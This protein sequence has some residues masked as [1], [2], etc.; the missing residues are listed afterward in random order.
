MV[1]QFFDLVQYRRLQCTTCAVVY[2]FPEGWCEKSREEGRSWKCPNGHGQWYGES[3]TDKIR[4][5]RDLLKQRIAQRDD[6]I[7]ENNKRIAEGERKLSATK[8]VVTRIKN[9]VGR[10]VCPCCNRTFEN[11]H[12][13]M[14]GQHPT[15]VSEAA[16]MSHL[17]AHRFAVQAVLNAAKSA[18]ATR[19]A[20]DTQASPQ[21][22][23]A[24][25]ATDRG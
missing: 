19:A 11:L 9:R 20:D 2:F 12:R 17:T 13:H 5:E 10:G 14:S 23:S 6:L 8:G 21:R 15:Y 22:P 24:A 16:E 3:E 7:A 18:S 25:T 4:R 1:Y